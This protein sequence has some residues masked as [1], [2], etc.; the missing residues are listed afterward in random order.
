MNIFKKTLLDVWVID[1]DT[2]VTFIVLWIVFAI[3]FAIIKA[4]IQA[5][6][7]ENKKENNASH[8]NKIYGESEDNNAPIKTEWATVIQKTVTPSTEIPNLML[9][10]ILFELKDG[11]RERFAIRDPMKY[12]EIVEGD[13]GNL[14]YQGK[15]FLNFWRE[16]SK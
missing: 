9:N 4:A 14:R 8:V 10:T 13:C 6:K 5:S 15:K 2:I 16:N 12:N 1:S 3:I 7:D 11:S